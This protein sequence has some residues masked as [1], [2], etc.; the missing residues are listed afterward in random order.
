MIGIAQCICR[1]GPPI[2]WFNEGDDIKD[3]IT[4]GILSND[5]KK[6]DPAASTI[7]HR[8]AREEDTPRINCSAPGNGAFIQSSTKSV[9]TI[10]VERI[11]VKTRMA[12]SMLLQ[13]QPPLTITTGAPKQVLQ[14]AGQVS[15]KSSELVPFV[16]DADLFFSGSGAHPDPDL[17]AESREFAEIVTR[18]LRLAD[19]RLG[20]E[21]DAAK[22]HFD[23]L[24]QRVSGIVEEKEVMGGVAGSRA[25][26]FVGTIHR[27]HQPEHL[28]GSQRRLGDLEFLE[29]CQIEPTIRD[30]GKSGLHRQIRRPIIRRGE[31]I[32][33]DPRRFQISHRRHG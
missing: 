31:S 3:S 5:Y 11:K 29:S 16:P 18:P 22:T 14:S 27:I 28:P 26:F 6:I 13:S 33:D 2:R 10:G 1:R 23:G 15:D 7:H 12:L 24:D 32:G 19:V 17:V 30:E 4:I 20:M 25:E 8:P 21:I 9:G